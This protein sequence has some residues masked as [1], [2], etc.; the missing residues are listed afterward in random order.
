MKLYK[1]SEKDSISKCKFET[2]NDDV[3]HKYQFD[4]RANQLEEDFSTLRR[5]THGLKM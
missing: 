1:D 2:Q 5:R 4:L 3:F